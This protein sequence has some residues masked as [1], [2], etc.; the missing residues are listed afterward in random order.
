MRNNV[1]HAPLVSVAIP[2]Y[3]QEA[4]LKETL[5]SVVAQDYPNMQIIVSDDAS[6]DGTLSLA[7]EFSDRYPELISV[8]SHG[9]NLGATANVRSMLDLIRGEYVCWFAGD[10]I[11]L[12]GK[13]S[14][15]VAAMEDNPE[16]VMSYH[17]V[18]VMSDGVDLYN[19]NEPGPGQKPYAGRVVEQLLRY[20][21]FISSCSV[22][23]RVSAT[24]GLAQR[25]EIKRASDWLY[26]V[27]I[28]NRGAVLYMDRV[29]AKY[30]RHANNLSKVV[31]VRDEERVYELVESLYPKYLDAIQSGR[32][33]LYLAYLFKY[34]TDRNW[35]GVRQ[36]VGKLFS[37]GI[38]DPRRLPEMVGALSDLVVQRL[39]LLQRTRHVVR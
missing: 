3:N 23:C 9:H 38:S 16:A 6:V 25:E 36:M 26:L 33:R 30:R 34:G 8:H 27:E 32:L 29:F 20:R 35:Y 10:D 5:E 22:M 28:A 39:Y 2:T 13:I 12:P 15:Q 18:A 31:D 24:A 17:E 14:A 11:M 19:Y 1:S 21:C 37:S 7:R 4:Y